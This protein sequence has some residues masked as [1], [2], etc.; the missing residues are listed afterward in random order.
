MWVDCRA[1]VTAN[2]DGQPRW[3]TQAKGSG[4]SV[5]LLVST[6]YPACAS[7]YSRCVLGGLGG[8]Q[9]WA[10]WWGHCSPTAA[11]AVP[12]CLPQRVAK[13]S[14]SLHPAL[15]VAG[16]LLL[17]LL[18]STSTAGPLLVLL[19]WPGRWGHPAMAGEP[20]V[21][22]LVGAHLRVPMHGPCVP[23][24]RLLIDL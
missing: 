21:P 12:P 11:A 22:P 14:Q 23:W 10:A 4:A 15:V 9:R 19:R 5:I 8:L 20:P 6:T 17:L 3:P 16:L 7:A 2:P 18:L 1:C 24:P 13:A